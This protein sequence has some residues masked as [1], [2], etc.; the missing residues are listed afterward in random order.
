MINKGSDFDKIYLYTNY[1]FESKYQ[2]LINR[3]EKVEIKKFKKQ[4]DSLIIHKKFMIFMI[5]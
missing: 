2:L 5:I 3:I 1:P 4:K